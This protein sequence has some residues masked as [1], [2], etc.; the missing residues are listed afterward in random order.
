M[1]VVACAPPPYK[2]INNKCKKINKTEEPGNLETCSQSH[3]QQVAK[4]RPKPSQPLSCCKIKGTSAFPLDKQPLRMK[5][6][7]NMTFHSKV[8]VMS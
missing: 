4:P 2:Q 8:V 1:H 7:L 3:S 6:L 5:V